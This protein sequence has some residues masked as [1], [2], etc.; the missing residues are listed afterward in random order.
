[1]QNKK[2]SFDLYQFL[3]SLLLRFLVFFINFLYLCFF[4][5]NFLCL[6]T[7]IASMFR[8]LSS[9]KSSHFSCRIRIRSRNL[10]GGDDGACLGSA[11]G[12]GEFSTMGVVRAS[13]VFRPF[14]CVDSSIV[15]TVVYDFFCVFACSS[16]ICSAKSCSRA[17]ASGVPIGTGGGGGMNGLN[18]SVSCCRD[19][20]SSFPGALS[21][22]FVPGSALLAEA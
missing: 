11:D 14:G 8:A 12:L 5:F 1:M 17:S 15:R 4:I 6:L 13:Y 9:L 22:C 20:P 16:L 3:S 21:R 10:V 7:L 19:M 2:P 18:L